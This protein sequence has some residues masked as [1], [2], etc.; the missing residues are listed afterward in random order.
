MFPGVQSHALAVDDIASFIMWA[1][2][3]LFLIVVGTMFLFVFKYHKKRHPH[4]TNIHGNVPL[5]VIW[6]VIPILLVLYMFYIGWTGYIQT[7]VVPKD[8]MPVKVIGRQW[9]WTFEYA[10]G[11]VADS[12]YVPEGTPIK[13]LIT[14]VDVIHGFYIPAFR[15]KQDALPDRVRYL[16]LYPE[17]VG[18][19]EI[20][21]S[22]Y[23]GLDHALME[24]RLVVLPKDEFNKWLN[25]GVS[26]EEVKEVA[27]SNP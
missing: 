20:T 8:A 15:E 10:N 19:Y 4:A 3:I 17:Q 14:S 6:T 21:C 26:K 11:K 13:C 2:I 1:D 27:T 18:N 7:R 16:M 22:Q 9:T 24:T 5:E 23:C 12:M 25:T